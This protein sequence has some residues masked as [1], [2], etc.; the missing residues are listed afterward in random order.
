MWL[1]FGRVKIFLYFCIS[2]HTYAMID[3][4]HLYIIAGCN[5][6]GKTTAAYTLLPTMLDCREFVNADEI[7]HG[8]SPFNPESMSIQAGKL[9]VGRIDRLLADEASFA[10]ETTLSTRSYVNL[11]YQARKKGYT[12]SLLFFWIESPEMAEMRVAKRVAEGGHNIP[13]ETIYRRYT[14]GLQNL[15]RLYMPCVDYWVIYDNSMLLRAVVAEGGSR[16]VECIYDIDIYNQM[17]KYVG[18]RS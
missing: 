15:F 2:F 11:I 7:A 10:I 8:L 6:A 1:F 14:L 3:S 16:L 17:R 13:K 5:G 12:A 4:K 18:R 9:M